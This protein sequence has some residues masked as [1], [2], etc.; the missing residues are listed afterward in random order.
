MMRVTRKA[1]IIVDGNRFGQGRL[2]VRWLKFALYKTRLW[3]L[4][5]CMMTR[6]KCYLLTS[7]DGLAYSYSVYDSFDCIAEWADQLIVIPAVPCKA[8]TWIHPLLTAG[9]VVVCALKKIGCA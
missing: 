8:T 4:V 5:N 7:G 2:P 1:V 9:G 3:K 6:G